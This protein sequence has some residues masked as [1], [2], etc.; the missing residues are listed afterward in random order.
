MPEALSPAQASGDEP[1]IGAISVSGAE[2]I[3]PAELSA[4]YEPFI[5]RAASNDAL[6]T[7]ARSVAEVA[8]QRGYLFASA[9]VPAQAVKLGVVRVRVDLGA[10]D[11]VRILGSSNSQLR[12][13][14]N[15]LVGPAPLRPAVE[16]Q[17]LLAE[18]LPG[19]T[20]RNTRYD[21][22]EGR[23][24][25]IVEVEEEK[26][27]WE[28]LAD[29]YGPDSLGPW[30]ARGTVDFNSLLRPGDTLGVQV[31][32]TASQPRELTFA[33][34]RYAMTTSGG[35]AQVGVAASAGSSR[36]GAALKTY[37]LESESLYAAVFASR[38]LWRTKDA[39]VWLNGEL[40][41]LNVDE[42]AA[43]ATIQHDEVA[44]ASV[45]VSATHAIGKGRLSGGVGVTQGLEMGGTTRRGDP[46][47]SRADA[48]GG[49]TKAVA[50]ANF[51]APIGEF[52]SVRIHALGQVASRALLASQ[53]IGLGGPVY[54]RAFD[55][56]ERFGDEGLMG[57]IELR[58][59]FRDFAGKLKDLQVYGFADAG[60]VSNKGDGYGGG[61]LASA[62]AG[63]RGRLGKTEFT[64]EVA[65]PLNTD[66]YESGDRSPS[67]NIGL[68]WR[69]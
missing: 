20:I 53:E 40:A 24:V 39:S 54:G 32:N 56:S 33:S 60:R 68:R 64:A 55:F 2:P 44:T 28:V 34:A 9:M 5:G 42:T 21:R 36:P 4:V 15:V 52:Y 62:G 25:L 47:A 48:G 14:L 19:V 27:S 50:W 35:A 11:E 58:R 65:A 29:N 43:G 8:R 69:F 41:Y 13:I 12:R 22:S 1:M 59:Q 37:D 57:S 63:L 18:D 61:A 45:N 30:R 49:F 6:R 7:L 17:L 51:W 67:V 26:I 46:M 38:A 31:L 10:V 16:R 3:A 23:G 66:R